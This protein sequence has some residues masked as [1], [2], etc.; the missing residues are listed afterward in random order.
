MDTSR[1]RLATV[2]DEPAIVD[3]IVLAFTADPMWR[4]A[5]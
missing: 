4:W 1:I 3:A 2:D 5:W